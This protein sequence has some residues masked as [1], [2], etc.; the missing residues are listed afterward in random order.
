MTRRTPQ[1]SPAYRALEVGPATDLILLAVAA[2][3][4]GLSE[5]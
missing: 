3:Q 4:A 2:G 5:P 1:Q